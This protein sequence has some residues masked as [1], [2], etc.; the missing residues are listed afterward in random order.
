ML[1]PNDAEHDQAAGLRRLFARRATTIVPL[2]AQAQAS[3]CLAANLGVA[4]ARVGRRTLIVDE[5]SGEVALAVGLAAR[6]ELAHVLAGDR[7][8]RQAVLAVAED[9]D[10]LPATR[11]LAQLAERGLALDDVLNEL[12]RRPA[13]VLV[14][15]C[16]ARRALFNAHGGLVIPI[17]A[18][19]AALT[20]A[21]TELKRCATRGS[22]IRAFAHSVADAD[23]AYEQYAALAAAATR[24]LASPVRYAGFVPQDA[25]FA[26]ARHERRT[27]FDVDAE[28]PSAR[29]LE[30]LAAKLVE[31]RQDR[32]L[33]TRPLQRAVQRLGRRAVQALPP[34][35]EEMAPPSTA[36]ITH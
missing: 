13:V 19:A 31:D 25:A 17:G 24:F 15:A 32:A 34:E 2:L 10:L 18:G 14:H 4:S 20:E 27:V 9:V 11:G 23:T 28:A 29:A 1:P 3:A 22:E 5:T 35:S 36:A 8:L 26:R 6:C 33:C 12:P 16:A 30:S 21:Y 7:T